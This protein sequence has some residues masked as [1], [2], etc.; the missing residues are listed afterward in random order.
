MKIT[1]LE[2][3]IEIKEVVS[4][5]LK[6]GQHIVLSKTKIE[7]INT[8]IIWLKQLATSLKIEYIEELDWHWK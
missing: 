2:E 8:I 5:N 6:S 7:D 4:L 1:E 3:I